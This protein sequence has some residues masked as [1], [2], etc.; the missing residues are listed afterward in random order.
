MYLFEVI[1]SFIIHKSGLFC[2]KIKFVQNCHR[3]YLIFRATMK[4]SFFTNH[5]ITTFKTEDLFKLKT[6]TFEEFTLVLTVSS[7]E[8]NPTTE[9]NLNLHFL[10]RNGFQFFV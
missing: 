9:L 6:V 7:F 8:G 5:L 10:L 2:V 4:L 3:L 1:L